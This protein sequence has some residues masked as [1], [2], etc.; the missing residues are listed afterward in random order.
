LEE[1]VIKFFLYVLGFSVLTP[2]VALAEPV[3]AIVTAIAALATFGMKMKALYFFVAMMALSEIAKS[4]APKMG[5]MG[6]N[7]GYDVSGP[8]PT[9]FQQVIYGRTR[10]G[11]VVV[12]KDT[13]PDDKYLHMVIAIA[14]HE[15]E[16]IEEIHFEDERLLFNNFFIN[17]MVNELEYV[18]V[19][20]YKFGT[21][22][23]FL[24]GFTLGI[25]RDVDG[26][27]SV[28][29]YDGSQTTADQTLIDVFP[30]QWTSKH[31][32]RGIS[33]VRISIKHDPEYFTSGEPRITF[34]VKGKKVYDPEDSQQLSN[35][36]STWLWSE[37]PALCLR[38][39]LTSEAGLNCDDS[40]IDDVSFMQ[41]KDDCVAG[42]PLYDYT[43]S[44]NT[45]ET[46]IASGEIR[47]NASTAYGVTKIFVSNTDAGGVSRQAYLLSLGLGTEVTPFN[48]DDSAQ[49]AQFRI[50]STEE[51]SGYVTINVERRYGFIGTTLLNNRLNFING[52]SLKLSIGAVSFAKYYTTN[53]AF[54]TDATPENVIT[55]IATSAAGNVF[56]SLGKFQFY[57]G[58]PRTATVVLTDDDVR[59]A[60]N[61]QT[62]RSRREMYN[63][64]N[65][66]YKSYETSWQ[67]SDYPSV[68]SQNA[69]QEDNNIPLT[70]S[71]DLLFTISASMA[72]RIAKILLLKTRQQ[73]QVQGVFGLRASQLAVGDWVTYRNNR[74]GID[75]TFEVLSWALTPNSGSGVA[76]ELTLQEV[77]DAVFSWSAAEEPDEINP[78]L[79][80][81][82]GRFVA[83]VSVHASETDEI[84]NEHVITVLNFEVKT[85]DTSLLD[86]CIVEYKPTLKID[87]DNPTQT[88]PVPDSEYQLVGQGSLGFFQVRD[89]VTERLL[90]DTPMEYTVRARGVNSVGARG[91]YD[92]DSIKVSP[93]VDPP[94]DVTNFSA[95]VNEGYTNLEWTPVE[96][97]DLSYYI[98]R[99]AVETVGAKMSHATTAVQKVSRPASTVAVP[100]R[101]GTYLIRAYDKLKIPSENATPVVITQNM[102]P[103]YTSNMTQ[104]DHTTFGGTKTGVSVTSGALHLS[105][106]ATA[107]SEG[108][109]VFSNYIDT[110]D[111]SNPARKVRASMHCKLL[112]FG[113]SGVWDEV[114][115]LLDESA[116][117]WDNL[118][119]GDDKVDV[120]VLFYISTTTDDPAGTPTWSDYQQFKAGDFYGR[121]FRFMVKLKSTGDGITPS[122]S[123][124]TAK[125]EY[126]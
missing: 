80:Q 77:S 37:N 76:F 79:V 16:G 115:G 9:A 78:P 1:T 118:T 20:S 111:V 10:V 48:M 104:S 62:K 29:T 126:N 24:S 26:L 66:L 72:K 92:T 68:V 71:I 49:F 64:L 33:Y 47:F 63:E 23:E 17:T 50:F 112:R 2:T 95:N 56:Y 38:D 25:D 39:Y 11:G 51:E 94:D 53:G 34:V 85:D 43:F 119:D 70:N 106:Y 81:N 32:L 87:P 110:Y 86:T 57:A 8:D 65:G 30:E 42:T 116:G 82:T 14:G 5:D 83:D 46:S 124:L 120:D 101:V 19:G 61:V 93:N 54:T 73:V 99:H 117:L 89:V 52:Q 36:P 15:I 22:A 28:K 3:T 107:P 91:A 97:L 123:E 102:L 69:L 6:V 55:S 125:V 75:G 41:A 96:N 21:T 67:K 113:D 59:G 109:Y 100:A 90:P 35:D 103:S 4:M 108:T 31:V 98:I 40:E 88:I 105:T 121:A 13:S 84:I 58:V 45:T 12:F 114:T 18:S 27:V 44:T 60:L 122:I 7:G 74:M